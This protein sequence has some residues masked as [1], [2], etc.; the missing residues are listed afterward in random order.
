MAAI[1]EAFAGSLRGAIQS[2]LAVVASC[3]SIFFTYQVFF[4]PLR[5]YPG[6]LLA[7]F[8]DAYNGFHTAGRR[9]HLVTRLNHLKYGPVV[10]QG[11][12]KLVFSTATAAQEIYRTDKTTKPKAYM[13]LGP[14]LKTYNVFTATDNRLH[15]QR[16]Q[17]VGQILTDRSMRSFEPTMIKQ[18]DIFLKN[19]LVSVQN[20]EPFDMTEQSR[21]LGLDISGLLAFGYDLQLQTNEESRFMLTMITAGT[22][23]SSVFLQYPGARRFSLALIAVKAFRQ[24]R[25][26]YLALVQRM[27]KTRL[28]EKVDA[29][30]DLFSRVAPA[31]NVEGENGLRDSELWA[32]ANL[33][34][35]AAG[36]TVK[37][38]LSAV[39]FYLARNERAYKRLAD[40]IRTTFKNSSDINGPALAQ[41]EYLRAC[42]DEALRMSPPASGILWREQAP[43]DQPLVIDGHVIPKGTIIGVNIYSLHHN[44]EYFPNSFEYRPERWLEDLDETSRKRMRDAFM[45]FSIG[46]RGCA[47]KTMAYS[48][49]GLVVAKTLWYFDFENTT[50]SMSR[51]GEGHPG[52]EPGR[53]NQGE[54]QLYDVFSAMHEGPY[55]TFKKRASYWEEL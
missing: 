55:L 15:R 28:A 31:L 29:K 18:V 24:L 44:E 10:R 40:E 16:R 42:I 12:N 51:I 26:P 7:K 50:G 27:I 46:P 33:F 19:L 43:S 45:P 1:Q 36:D 35:T 34:L 48:E 4:H 38:A 17:L 39:F 21:R 8:T 32:E 14:G 13:A 52:L 30:H 22:F 3:F 2:A 20:S 47:G 53:E 5:N 23:W 6:P 41:C 49:T 11:P 9:L 25:E 37:T 54:F